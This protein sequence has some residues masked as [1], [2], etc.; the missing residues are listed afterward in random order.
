MSWLTGVPLKRV[1]EMAVLIDEYAEMERDVREMKSSASRYGRR[2]Y[3]QE[4]QRLLQMAHDLEQKM[5][6]GKWHDAKRRLRQQQRERRRETIRRQS[7]Y[8][9]Q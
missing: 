7:G 4:E 2:G 1:D 3:S 8:G 5:N 6:S 9:I